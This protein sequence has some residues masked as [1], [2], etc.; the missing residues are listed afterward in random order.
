MTSRAYKGAPVAAIAARLRAGADQVVEGAPREP[1]SYF[2]ES[3]PPPAEVVHARVTVAAVLPSALHVAC[4]RHGAA[5]G[6]RCYSVGI[7]GDRMRRRS[8]PVAS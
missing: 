8:S 2:Y 7:C 4:E 1:D 3:D 6:E 5:V